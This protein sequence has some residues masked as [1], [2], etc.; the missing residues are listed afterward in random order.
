VAA[1]HQPGYDTYRLV[2]TR[3]I[4]DPNRAADASMQSDAAPVAAAPR[5]AA[6]DYAALTGIMISKEKTLA[7]FSGSR[8]EFNKVLAL[9]DAIAGAVIAKISATSIEVNRDGK[10]ITVAIGQTLPLDGSAA[11]GPAPFL[12]A[13]APVPLTVTAEAA[14]P[15]SSTATAPAASDKAALIQRMME[16]RNKELQK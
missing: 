6:A 4:F 1:P 14:S 8:P 13:P 5:L 2:Q 12:A 3:N 15:S 16:R 10:E 11:P 9:N 7:F